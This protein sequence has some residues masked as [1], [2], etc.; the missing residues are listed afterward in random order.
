[1]NQPA[2]PARYRVGIDIGGTFTDVVLLDSATQELHFGKVST[3][4]RDPA[5]GFFNGLSKIVRQSE[6][7]RDGAEGIVHG[8]TIATNAVLERRGSRMGLLVTAGFRDMFE[9]GRT[10][11]GIF[12]AQIR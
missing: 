9:I 4:P 8:S 11:T 2:R 5:N 1:M 10:V 3:T 7:P 12:S 6:R